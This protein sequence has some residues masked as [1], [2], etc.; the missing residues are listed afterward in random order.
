MLRK[1]TRSGLPKWFEAFSPVN[2]LFPD[3]LWK[4]FSQ[5]YWKKQDVVAIRWK[6]HMYNRGDWVLPAL[7]FLS[8][9]C[10]RIEWWKC[11]CPRRWSHLFSRH[12]EEHQGTIRSF[13]DSDTPTG[14]RPEKLQHY[15]QQNILWVRLSYWMF[16][17][18]TYFNVILPF[19]MPP[20]KTCESMRCELD[21]E[22]LR[23][24]GWLQFQPQSWQPPQTCTSP[25]FH[26][27]T[28]PENRIQS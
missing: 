21:R 2:K 6:V 9:I 3:N 16:L 15:W 19:C 26:H 24:R 4:W 18:F 11:V 1:A 10:E 13:Y 20:L 25:G 22:V 12:R 5:I 14:N 23:R 7:L 8:R 28:D 27:Q 17:P